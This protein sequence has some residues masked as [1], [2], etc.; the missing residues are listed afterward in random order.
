MKKFLYCLAGG[1]IP[2]LIVF[3]SHGL[4]QGP[5]AQ[6]AS[7]IISNG[8]F[9]S[10]VIMIGVALLSWIANLGQFTSLK[11]IGHML[12]SMFSWGYPRRTIKTYGEFKEEI[13]SKEEKREFKHLLLAGLVYFAVSLAANIIFNQLA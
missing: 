7:L 4:F 2:A 11:Y 12:K 10:A 1:F 3:V 5:S 13:E 8:C 9:L 6:T